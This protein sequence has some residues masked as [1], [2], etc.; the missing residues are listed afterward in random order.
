M[1]SGLHKE[2]RARY[3]KNPKIT[4]VIW[5]SMKMQFYER[6][7][8]LVNVN[9]FVK[10][11]DIIFVDFIACFSVDFLAGLP[12]IPFKSLRRQNDVIEIMNREVNMQMN[13]RLCN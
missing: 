10:S 3:K 13:E 1:N 8:S 12:T 5:D 11:F 9:Y 6:N 2:T 7:K 4:D